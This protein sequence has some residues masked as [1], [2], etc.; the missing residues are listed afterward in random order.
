MS[1]VE[2][3]PESPLG[4]PKASVHYSELQACDA[5]ALHCDPEVIEP[6]ATKHRTASVHAHRAQIVSM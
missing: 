1:D 4:S 2:D 6:N 5:T 3:C